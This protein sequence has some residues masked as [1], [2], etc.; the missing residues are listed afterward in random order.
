MAVFRFV[1]RQFIKM[2][3]ILKMILVGVYTVA[4]LSIIVIPYSFSVA[5]VENPLKNTDYTAAPNTYWSKMREGISYGKKTQRVTII[6]K[7]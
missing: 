7:L 1:E 4:I 2:K 5:H 6:C 3:N